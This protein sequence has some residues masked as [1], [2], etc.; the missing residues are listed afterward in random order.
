[1][2][3]D[4]GKMP[5]KVELTLEQSQQGVSDDVLVLYLVPGLDFELG[6]KTL[7]NDEDLAKCVECGARNYY[8]LH[9]YV[10]HFVFD[11]HDATATS[12]QDY[13]GKDVTP[14]DKS[15]DDKDNL[16]DHWPVNDPNI[17]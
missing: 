11:L 8:V 9:I 7:E 12:Q 14:N 10:S 3:E 5:T 6:L 1:M 15:T 4:K 17:K 16:G 13:V 2:N